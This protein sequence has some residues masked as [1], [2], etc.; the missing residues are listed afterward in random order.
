MKLEGQVILT[1]HSDILLNGFKEFAQYFDV[2][3]GQITTYKDFMKSQ[4][5]YKKG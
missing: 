4:L 2:G 1:T 3:L 5:S